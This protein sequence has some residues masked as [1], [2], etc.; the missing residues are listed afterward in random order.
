MVVRNILL[1]LHISAAI[2]IIG[3]LVFLDMLMP[4]MV[5]GGR[6]NLPALR[7]LHAM[8]KVF[9]PSALIVFL[10]GIALVLKNHWKFSHAWIGISMLLF[11]I[12]AVLGAVVMGKIVETAIGKIEAGHPTDAEAGRLGMIGGINILIML[13]IVYLMVAKPGGVG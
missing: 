5:R 9:G 10:L 1:W 4:S 8:S 13:T 7:R 3:G 6:D 2:I 12:A 11:V